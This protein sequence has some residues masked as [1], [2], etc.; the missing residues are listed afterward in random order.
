M[1]LEKL[2]KCCFHSWKYNGNERYRI[3]TKCKKTQ[4]HD[5]MISME[6]ED[7]KLSEKEIKEIFR[8]L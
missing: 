8:D 2:L 3:C 7:V 4:M 1:W 5:C 6:Y